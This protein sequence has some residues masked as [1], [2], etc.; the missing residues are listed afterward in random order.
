MGT[1]ILLIILI[2]IGLLINPLITGLVVGLV[3][4]ITVLCMI[5]TR[6][7]DNMIVSA[8]VIE[9]IQVT[10]EQLRES[11]FSIGW[12]G[13]PR[14]YWSID[15]VPSHIEVRVSVVYENGK[16]RVL[17]LIEGSGRYNRI[18]SICQKRKEVPCEVLPTVNEVL[19]Q[20]VTDTK[21]DYIDVKTNQL[22][23]GVYVIGELIPE[24]NYDFR[25]IW[26][27]GRFEKYPDSTCTYHSDTCVT[28]NVGNE[29]E[30]QE[31]VLVN[32]VCKTGEYLRI[33]GNLIVEI[34]KSK[35]VVLDL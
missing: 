16:R 14:M 31:R 4:V 20:K 1:L 2:G 5:A 13:N 19:E 11:G 15:D 32:V 27:S 34:R 29:H 22:V 6:K 21:V 30:Y 17:T 10:K 3:A 18:M 24:G 26:G 23:A 12:H 28:A 33:K 7:R 25:W 35:P 9:R 8:E